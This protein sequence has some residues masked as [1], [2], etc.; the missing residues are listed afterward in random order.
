MNKKYQ[1]KIS[2]VEDLDG[3]CK[4]NG[5]ILQVIEYED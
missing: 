5:F 4:I 1:A 2:G 3:V